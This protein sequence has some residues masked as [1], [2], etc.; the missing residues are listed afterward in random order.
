LVANR[1]VQIA[2]AAV[3]MSGDAGAS[4]GIPAKAVNPW[5]LGTNGQQ[6]MLWVRVGHKTPDPTT[7]P[8]RAGMGPAREAHLKTLSG[9]PAFPEKAQAWMDRREAKQFGGL[10]GVNK[11][12]GEKA[13]YAAKRGSAHLAG[14][15]ARTA[16]I[17]QGLDE[18]T[19]EIHYKWIYAATFRKLGEIHQEYENQLNRDG[20]SEETIIEYSEKMKVA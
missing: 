3:M 5:A 15:A 19:A 16:A 14:T 4:V 13:E 17:S 11:T 20:I 10:R 7:A 6:E 2:V 12:V 9:L 8:F 1:D 18:A